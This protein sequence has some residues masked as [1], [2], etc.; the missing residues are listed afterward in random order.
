MY[1][2][3][4]SLFAVSREVSVLYRFGIHKEDNQKY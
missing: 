3:G 1:V 2:T 4:Y